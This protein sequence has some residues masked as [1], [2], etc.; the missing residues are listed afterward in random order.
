MK[1]EYLFEMPD[2]LI[3]DVVKS[4]LPDEQNQMIHATI[5]Y[6]GV[7]DIKMCAK[8]SDKVSSRILLKVRDAR[9]VEVY[10]NPESGGTFYQVRIDGGEVPLVLTPEVCE[11]FMN[12]LARA[13]RK[14]S[15]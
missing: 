2:T 15:I 12:A 8:G 3:S 11:K 6:D 4:E 5:D 1:T 10:A 13:M 9:A 14:T 7:L